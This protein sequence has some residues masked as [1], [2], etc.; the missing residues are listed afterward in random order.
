M[1]ALIYRLNRFHVCYWA[2]QEA[3]D[4]GRPFSDRL[5]PNN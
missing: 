4:E 3:A 5:Y 1:E 2:R